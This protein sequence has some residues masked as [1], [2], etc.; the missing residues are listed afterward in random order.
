MPEKLKPCPACGATDINVFVC[1]L[2]GDDTEKLYRHAMCDTCY[3]SGPIAA[4]RDGAIAN[5]NA[6]PRRLRW[7][8]EPPQEPGWYWYRNTN[9]LD[10]HIVCISYEWDEHMV[11]FELAARFVLETPYNW[12]NPHPVVLMDGEWAGPIPEPEE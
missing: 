10:V 1:T 4:T 7:T 2:N 12:H 3:T 11:D 8:T 9:K 5:W 6:L